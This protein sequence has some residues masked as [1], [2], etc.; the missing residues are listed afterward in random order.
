M[1]RCSRWGRGRWNLAGEGGGGGGGQGEGIKLG[2][3]AGKKTPA[4]TVA[5]LRQV[6]SRLLRTPPPSPGQIADEVNR[7]L[8]RKEEARIYHWYQKTKT[9]PPR[10]ETPA[11]AA[12]APKKKR[13]Q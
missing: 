4:L 3:L 2:K 9:F 10:R 8:R 7:V 12:G 13:L 11:S 6:F 5:Q 1:R